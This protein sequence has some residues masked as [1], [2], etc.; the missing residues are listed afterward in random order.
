MKAKKIQIID[1]T[2]AYFITHLVCKFITGKWYL[3]KLLCFD[4]F[5]VNL[6]N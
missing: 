1:S 4:F 2:L 3:I 6:L 5:F